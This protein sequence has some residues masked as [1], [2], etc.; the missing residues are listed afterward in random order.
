M[1]RADAT[2]N[3]LE[4][5]FLVDREVPH[6]HAGDPREGRDFAWQ[7]GHKIIH[8]PPR[9]LD[10]NGDARSRVGNEPVQLKLGGQSID[11]GAEADTLD[12]AEDLEAFADSCHAA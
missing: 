7:A 8:L 2:R 12:Y 3:N 4:T 1:F 6:L 9:P 5:R 11:I 10:F